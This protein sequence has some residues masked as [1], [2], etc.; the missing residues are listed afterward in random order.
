MVR[1]NVVRSLRPGHQF[2]LEVFGETSANMPLDRLEY[3][4][5]RYAE[6]DVRMGK[7]G[8]RTWNIRYP[9]TELGGI[10]VHA[11][12]TAYEWWQHMRG[13]IAERESFNFYVSVGTPLDYFHGVDAFFQVWP[14]YAKYPT[15][16]S[17]DLTM[18]PFDR[19][20]DD[21][22]QKADF[23]ICKEYFEEPDFFQ[24]Y[25]VANAIGY[26]LSHRQPQFDVDLVY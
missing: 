6:A 5:R 21:E 24:L 2:E 16:V 26:T 12:R 20:L 25:A 15:T 8:P 18:I 3:A 11:V 1:A 17:V 13:Y 9:K 14:G 10:F 4:N 23:V 19:I 22:K 7:H